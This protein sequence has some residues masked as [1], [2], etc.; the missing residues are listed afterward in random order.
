M[1]ETEMH[2]QKLSTAIRLFAYLLRTDTNKNCK[3]V[4]VIE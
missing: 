4:C 2:F 3:N 1:L